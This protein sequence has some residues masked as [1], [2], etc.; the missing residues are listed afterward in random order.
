MSI[1]RIL[2][3]CLLAWAW[4]PASW[5]HAALVASVPQNGAVLIQAPNTVQLHFSEPVSTTVLRLIDPAGQASTLPPGSAQGTDLRIAMPDQAGDGTY[6]LS[7]RV[8]SADGHPIGGTLAYTISADSSRSTTADAQ[9]AIPTADSEVDTRHLL[10]WLSRWLVYGCLFFAVGAALFRALFPDILGQIST[11]QSPKSAQGPAVRHHRRR[12]PSYPMLLAGAG[13]ILLPFSLALQGLDLLAAPWAQGFSAAVWRQAAA[14][15]YAVTLGLM[16]LALLL[17][18]VTMHMHRRVTLRRT[19]LICLM[20]AGAAL[21]VSGHA[22]TAPPQSWARTAIFLHAIAAMIWIGTLVPLVQALRPD[23]PVGASTLVNY[24]RWIPWVVALLVLSGIGLIWLQFQRPADLWQTAYGQVLAA[25]LGLVTLLLCIAAVNRWKLTKPTLQGLRPARLQLRRNIQ[26][27]IVLAILI[28]AIVS[29]WRF[30][31][32][33]RSL[34]QAASQIASL[35]QDKPSFPA[36]TLSISR[37]AAR[38]IP[39]TDGWAIHLSQ[40]DGQP[41]AAEAL[42]LLLSNPTAGIETI[43]TPASQKNSGLWTANPPSLPATGHWLI[44]VH[45]LVDDF[46]QISLSD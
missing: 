26:L 21:A 38:I 30:T 15:P 23:N 17:A 35:A 34:D 22:S 9:T 40:P 31:P 14:S 7:W 2:L 8:V 44:G 20:L 19:S 18:A 6:L 39:G 25:K 4:I 5:G 32:P 42:T 43:E 13:M 37:V 12:G 10:I 1:P 45:I 46:E 33:P 28:L 16:A 41:F 29:L 24:S 27:E 36:T 11:Q 3:I